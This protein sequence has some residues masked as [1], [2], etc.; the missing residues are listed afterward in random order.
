M[1]DVETHTDHSGEP[2]A[3]FR[4]MTEGT[5]EDWAAIAGFSSPSPP[6]LQPA[7]STISNCSMAIMAA[8]L[9]TG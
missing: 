6:M 3:K 7:C 9:S 2:R 5:Q 4:A 8:F 1:A